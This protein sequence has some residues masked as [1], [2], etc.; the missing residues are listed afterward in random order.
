[1]GDCLWQVLIT[2]DLKRWLGLPM[3][4]ST[5]CLYTRSGR[6]QLPYSKLSEEVKALKARVYT[7]FE[8]SEDPC[9]QGARLI[10]DGG[11]SVWT[12]GQGGPLRAGLSPGEVWSQL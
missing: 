9:V 6:L 4:L 12:R 2:G 8:E 11:V 10:V 1:M 7:A 3:S 5:A